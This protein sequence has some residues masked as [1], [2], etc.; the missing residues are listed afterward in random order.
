[1]SC[2]S[3][4]AERLSGK[5]S[6]KRTNGLFSLSPCH[7]SLTDNCLRVRRWIV[8]HSYCVTCWDSLCQKKFDWTKPASFH[9][10][11]S[12]LVWPQYTSIT[13]TR[14]YLLK[15]SA[16][17][18]VSFFEYLEQRMEGNWIRFLFS[19][20]GERLPRCSQLKSI[21]SPSFVFYIGNNCRF[22]FL[23]ALGKTNW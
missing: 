5:P 22:C 18:V 7:V 12:K 14:K 3:L 17:F 13:T 8:S 16:V 11:W 2:L 21:S 9:I 4:I 23:P 19:Q 6:W 20:T 10:L 1:M 15:L